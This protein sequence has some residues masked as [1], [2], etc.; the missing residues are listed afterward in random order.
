MMGKSRDDKPAERPASENATA[1]DYV[2]TK[3]EVEAAAAKRE[4]EAELAKASRVETGMASPTDAT[5]KHRG[6]IPGDTLQD[7]TD[8]PIIEDEP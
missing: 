7:T 4:A 6:R 8:E 1:V 2:R 3:Q 5:S